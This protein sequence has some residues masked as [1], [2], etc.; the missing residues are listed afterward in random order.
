MKSDARRA[1]LALAPVRVK[2]GPCMSHLLRTGDEAV[3]D[4]CDWRDLKAGDLIALSTP[5]GPVLHRFIGR[6]RGLLLTKGDRAP[7]FDRLT[8]PEALLGRVGGIVRGGRILR[9]A[10]GLPLRELPAVT[11]SLARGLASL[12]R[13]RL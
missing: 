8:P 13:R 2:V 7:A 5:A 4:P 9:R 1:A 3:L 12:V 6:R 10:R 11:A